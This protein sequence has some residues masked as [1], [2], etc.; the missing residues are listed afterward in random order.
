MSKIEMAQPICLWDLTLAHDTLLFSSCR[1]HIQR[2][3]MQLELD[4]YQAAVNNSYEGTDGVSSVMVASVDMRLGAIPAVFTKASC[5][6]R[7]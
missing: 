7:R 1:D 5:T 3:R 4:K 6:Q 2:H